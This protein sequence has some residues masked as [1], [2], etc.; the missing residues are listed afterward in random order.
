MPIELATA[1][2]VPSGEYAISPMEPLPKRSAAPLGNPNRALSGAATRG[3]GEQLKIIAAVN[4]RVKVRNVK[5]FMMDFSF[6]RKRVTWPHLRELRRLFRNGIKLSLIHVNYL[7]F[8]KSRSNLYQLSRKQQKTSTFFCKN[9]EK[10]QK[11]PR[12]I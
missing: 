8:G 11:R 4:N 7:I 12:L 1:S 9:L 6:L 2:N 5:F 3:R 10:C